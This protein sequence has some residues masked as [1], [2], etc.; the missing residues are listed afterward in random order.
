MGY[1]LRKEKLYHGLKLTEI[2][3]SKDEM[4]IIDS[5]DYYDDDSEWD[6]YYTINSDV[7]LE[8][9]NKLGKTLIPMN[10]NE[11]TS[12][13]NEF[14]NSLENDL[15]KKLFLYILSIN[16]KKMPEENI[17]KDGLYG[18]DL[19]KILCGTENMSVI[20]GQKVHKK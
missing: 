13:E 3:C 20:Y 11:F 12:K 15:F 10:I 17:D 7:F 19:I 2:Q 8:I 14:Y 4:M 1:I 18:S 16:K 9:I 5:T 6:E